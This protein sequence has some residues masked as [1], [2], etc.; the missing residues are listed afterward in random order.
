MFN[1]IQ[2]GMKYF[3]FGA[4][5]EKRIF[6][7]TSSNGSNKN[8]SV[9]TTCWKFCNAYLWDLRN[10]FLHLPAKLLMP[11]QFDGYKEETPN[12]LLMQIMRLTIEH[13]IEIG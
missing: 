8:S 4:N 3:L 13:G 1:P 11:K 10:S 12:K 7:L 6:L 2:Y 5:V 9:P